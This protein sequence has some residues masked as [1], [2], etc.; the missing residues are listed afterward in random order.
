MKKLLY[1]FFLFVFDEFIL[2]AQCPP[3]DPIVG[4]TQLQAC[5]NDLTYDYFIP[6]S[7]DANLQW[8][9]SPPN[10]GEFV[11][12]TTGENVTIDFEESGIVQL[13]ATPTNPC[14]DDPPICLNITVAPAPIMDQPSF[15]TVCAGE[16]VY[17]HL[18]SPDDIDLYTWV[19][20][21]PSI[22]LPGS[23]SGDP[24]FI[25][26]ED[27]S[28]PVAG[29]INISPWEGDC[30]GIPKILLIT[31]VPLPE[32]NPP[33]NITVCQGASV[34]VVFSGSSGA[35]FT[36]TNSNTDIGLGASGTGNLSFNA[37]NVSQQEVGTI[38]VTP[39]IGGCEGDPV[40]FDI[41]VNP[42][43]AMDEPPDVTVCAGQPVSVQFS[44]Q[45]T[46]FSW[47]NSNTAIGLGASGTGNL[48][49]T[50][51][52]VAAQQTATVTVTPTGGACP[53]YPETFSIT[54]LP[55]PSV[56]PIANI[57]ACGGAAVA[58]TFGGT[59]GATFNWT[60]SNPAI[61]LDASGT[62]NI[63]FTAAN[64]LQQE[65]GTISVTP[66]LDG[67]AGP[68]KSF[69]ITIKPQ[70]LMDPP[71]DVMTCGGADL[72]VGFSGPPGSAYAWTNSNPAIGLGPAGTG[73][74]AFTANNSALTQTSIV[75]VTPT[76]LGCAGPSQ[77]FT[78]SVLPA[79]EVNPLSNQVV[80][81]GVAVNVN[82]SGT[83]GTTFNWTN[84]NPAIGLAA[85]G[86]G[87]LNFSAAQVSDTTISIITVTPFKGG[88]AG[89][90]QSF[91]VTVIE[92]CATSAGTLDT[93]SIA[94][95][96]PK[97]VALAL[98][99]NHH[100]EP[101]DTIR[102]ILYSNPANPLG[103]IV[104]YSDTLYF[105]FLPGIMDFGQPYYAAVLAGPLLPNDSI[106]VA[107][108]CFSMFKGPQVLWR[109]KPTI[110]VAMPPG[111][112]CSD[113]CADVVFDFTG[114]PPFQFTWLIVQ[115]GQ[116]LLSKTETSATFQ[117]MVTVCPS[118][119]DVPGTG[120]Y[121]DF[122]VNFLMDMFCGCGD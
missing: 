117:M 120:G 74:I 23:G 119:F 61:G 77:S 36:W 10:I 99:G 93:N 57:T 63:A 43:P 102:F 78:I 104:Q 100:L 24:D 121:I 50:T 108:S 1:F 98:P 28:V 38:T 39:A 64:V 87:N 107:A 41:T 6:N 56:N 33:P 18:T 12:G 73:D 34:N 96:G 85:S 82:F 109:A 67:C 16:A 15:I 8:A 54:I 113:G 101:G 69:Q 95:C 44:G 66:V 72:S 115:G 47:T 75:T 52:N 81:E 114:T 19:N 70:P 21:N 20:N 97:T 51:A 26:T 110:A 118:D 5:T 46:G 35:T 45:G 42:G 53:G 40:T 76:L 4:P 14:Y 62:G 71:P 122:Q 7:T 59:A 90:P 79:P 86:T 9:L 91:S 55:L 25:A 11:G 111:S 103:S 58:V 17:V 65:T 37:A 80:C 22:G 30:M 92:C 32:V 13:C 105:P 27:F 106:N 49:F 84:S 94:V 83:A 68:P 3:L 2:Q 112:V 89:P 116:V 88:C 29:T 31:V 60:N 48:N